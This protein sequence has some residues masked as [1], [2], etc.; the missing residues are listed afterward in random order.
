NSA[1]DRLAMS[2]MIGKSVTVDKGRFTHQKGN[3]SS[4]NFDLPEDAEHIKLTV[5]NEKGDEV[6][7]RDL[8]PMK[9]GSHVY[10]W[11]GINESQAPSVSGTYMVRVDAENTKG[12]KIKI[13]PISHETI[14]GV[15]FEGGDTNFLVGDQKSPQR[16]AFKNVIRIDT[17]AANNR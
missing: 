14:V 15:S 3:L 16:V 13:D 1:S 7:K 6:A 4:L 9:A 2:A 8:E 11:D 10:N 12:T 17:T 5:L